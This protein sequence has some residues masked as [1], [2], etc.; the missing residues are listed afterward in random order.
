MLRRII[1]I[2]EDKCIGCGLFAK[3]CHEG[4]IENA[5]KRALRSSGKFLPREV[6]TISTDGRILE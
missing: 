6:V 3:A 5:A 1:R 4:N 2:D